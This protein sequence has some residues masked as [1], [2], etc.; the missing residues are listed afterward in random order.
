[1]K[2][3]THIIVA[4]I[5]ALVVLTAAVYYYLGSAPAPVESLPVL[6]QEATLDPLPSHIEVADTPEK[7]T[8]GLSGRESIADNYGMLFIF[9]EPAYHGFWMKDMR[10][11][12]DIIWIS[13]TGTIVHIEHELSPDTYPDV[14]T[15]PSPARY[16]LETRAGYAREHDWEEG[17]QLD[18]SAYE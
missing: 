4:G 3:K 18:L 16:V 8:Q 6:E 15:P 17:T 10:V 9:S 14:F 13:S 7:R 1:M 12:I 5:A 2:G 11:P